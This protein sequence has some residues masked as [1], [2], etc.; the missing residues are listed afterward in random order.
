MNEVRPE[1]R[2]RGG[3]S[4]GRATGFGLRNDVRTVQ[5]TPILASAPEGPQA[6][7]QQ[8]VSLQD[9]LSSPSGDP[10]SSNPQT[11]LRKY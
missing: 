4:R 8:P 11:I 6:P 2:V 10:N 1:G 7:V 5:V 9:T 3:N